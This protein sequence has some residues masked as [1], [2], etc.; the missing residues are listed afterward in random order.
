VHV[1][2]DFQQFVFFL[3]TLELHRVWQRLCVVACPNILVFCDSSCGSSVAAAY[4]PC[5]VCYVVSFY[6]RQ[7]IS[8]SFVLLAPDPGE[9]L[10]MHQRLSWIDTDSDVL[11]IDFRYVVVVCYSLL[12]CTGLYIRNSY[13]RIVSRWVCTSAVWYL[14][15]FTCVIWRVSNYAVCEWRDNDVC[16]S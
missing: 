12:L 9:P 2:L 15:G 7:K 5:S 10:P 1:P 11:L 3:L 16:L 14:T 13:W 8:S 6:V 4:E